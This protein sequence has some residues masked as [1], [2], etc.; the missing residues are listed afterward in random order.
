MS[1]FTQFPRTQYDIKLNKELYEI[2]DIFRHVDINEKLVDGYINYKLERIGDGERPDQMSQR[3]YNS[4]DYYWTFFIVNDFLKN[5]LNAWPKGLH[6]IDTIVQDDYHKYSVLVLDA[7]N[8]RKICNIP[9]ILDKKISL[10]SKTDIEIHKIDETRQQIWLKGNHNILNGVNNIGFGITGID[11]P[12][13][14][15]SNVASLSISNMVE[16]NGTYT[17][18]VD[19]NGAPSWK[20]VDENG[21]TNILAIRPLVNNNITY[22]VWCVYDPVDDDPFHNEGALDG[23]GVYRTLE[24]SQ[25]ITPWGN[26]IVGW[27]NGSSTYDPSNY[28]IFDNFVYNIAWPY[29]AL[30]GF[31]YAENAPYSYNVYDS[32]TGDIIQTTDFIS[33][34]KHLENE[35][36]ERSFI[37]VVQPSLI[38]TFTDEYK[39]LINE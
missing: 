9:N 15:L 6:Q 10:A 34:K 16:G 19:I 24:S 20:F 3:L 32:N 18:D 35:D 21:D 28:P 38:N 4:S 22:H 17:R 31:A 5:G 23:R 27:E 30:D 36:E 8:I 13:E 33:Y 14:D 12:T 11:D 37:K 2:V 25:S 39:R 1:F 26:S 7:E 29:E